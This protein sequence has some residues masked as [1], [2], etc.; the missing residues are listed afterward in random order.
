MMHSRLLAPVVTGVLLTSIA[1]SQ[2]GNWPEYRGPTQ[3]GRAPN[4]KVPLEWSETKNIHWK[5]KLPGLGHSSPVVWGGLVFITTAE[6]TGGNKLFTG[7]TPD[8]AHNNMN[9]LFDHQFAVMAIDRQTGAVVWRRTVATRQPH[10]STHESATWASNSPVT[11]GEHVLSF[12]GSNG[13]YCLD[14][15]GRLLW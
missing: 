8:G 9:P 15:G 6:M 10:E 7:V 3:H 4:A 2:N 14:T 11:D 1:C 13:L 5:T 12:F